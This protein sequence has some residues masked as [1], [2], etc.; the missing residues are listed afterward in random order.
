[1][2]ARRFMILAVVIG[3]WLP[4]DC[5]ATALGASSEEI[6]FVIASGWHTEVAVPEF[7]ASNPLASLVAGFPMS[8]YLVFGWGARDFYMA[9]DPGFRELLRAAVPG[10]AVLLVIP[11]AVSPSAYFGATN[12]W[13]VA[14]S[15]EGA[16][17]LARFLSEST[18]KGA[19]GAPIRVG[20]GPYPYSV[21]Y[22]ATGTYDASNTCNTW[23]AEALRAA[24]LQ[25]TA[26]GVVFANQLLGQLHR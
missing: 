9:R 5:S 6:I 19:N 17:R 24:G 12:V 26:A 13:P 4:T 15:R 22:A 11:L 1:M 8:R 16:A 2:L 3:L 25:V 23:T 20:N 18:A 10:P 14:V 7:A 21:F